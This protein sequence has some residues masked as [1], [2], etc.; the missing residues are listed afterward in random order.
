MTIQANA[1]GVISGRF[2]IPANIPAG[3]KSVVMRGVGGSFGETRYTGNG[4]I[5]TNE[6]T[7]VITRI[8]GYDPLAQTFTLDV[9]HQVA[10]VDLWFTTIGEK[11][12]R[13]QLRE[14][15]RFTEPRSTR[16]VHTHQKPTE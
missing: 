7:R 9:P 16:R 10:G 3:T 2:T 8:R 4:T 13:V 11:D 12:V 6:L 5:I 1:N 14:T 15:Y